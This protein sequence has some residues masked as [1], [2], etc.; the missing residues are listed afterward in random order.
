VQQAAEREQQVR[1]RT[2]RDLD[3][4]RVEV[5]VEHRVEQLAALPPIL[6]RHRPPGELREPHEQPVVRLE[7]G[8]PLEDLE[9]RAGRAWSVSAA[10]RVCSPT[11]IVNADA[12]AARICSSVVPPSVVPRQSGAMWPSSEPDRSG[13]TIAS[14]PN[15]ATISRSSSMS[16]GDR[17]RPAAA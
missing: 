11:P 17:W 14:S 13:S 10:M 4:A 8:E 1:L 9:R 16:A 3:P 6:V 7:P 12:P 15:A 5:A 2:E